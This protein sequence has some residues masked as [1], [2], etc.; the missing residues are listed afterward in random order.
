MGRGGI[1]LS[2][3]SDAVNVDKMVELL[4]EY[5]RTDEVA[6]AAKEGVERALRYQGLLMPTERNTCILPVKWKSPGLRSTLE[7]LTKHNLFQKRGGTSPIETLLSRQIHE[8][9]P[10]MPRTM[11][12]R[13][14]VDRL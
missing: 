12:H 14:K 7:W 13:L 8:M 9:I 2:R 10:N 4:R 3:L 1:G 6:A 11:L 5:R